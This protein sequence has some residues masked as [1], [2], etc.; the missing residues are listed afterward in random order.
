MLWRLQGNYIQIVIERMQRE[1]RL[2]QEAPSPS[3]GVAPQQ[4]FQPSPGGAS[5]SAAAAPSSA[6]FR[7]R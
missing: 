1:E 3:P 4:P 2:K 7:R 5:P 6:G